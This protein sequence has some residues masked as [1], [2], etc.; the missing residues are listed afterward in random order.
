MN[1]KAYMFKHIVI[2]AG[3]NASY[4][5]NNLKSDGGFSLKD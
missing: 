5:K 4:I 2:T 3:G 1:A